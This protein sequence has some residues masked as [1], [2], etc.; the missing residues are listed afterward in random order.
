MSTSLSQPDISKV[1]YVTYDLQESGFTPREPVI[2]R[3]A[4]ETGIDGDVVRWE[5][6]EFKRA[7]GRDVYAVRILYRPRGMW[8][9]ALKEELVEVPADAQ[10]V[11]VHQ[12]SLPP[13]YQAG[14]KS[15]A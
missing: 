3:G 13:E 6:G 14:L 8:A 4:K 5:V 11:Q 2:Y 15:A 12:A 7:W 9:G 1:V 10:N